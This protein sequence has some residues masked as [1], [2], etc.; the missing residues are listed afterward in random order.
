MKE[1]K[2]VEEIDPVSHLGSAYSV[3]RV[4]CI[5]MVA[6]VMARH[7]GA[8]RVPICEGEH[9]LKKFV[10]LLTLED[11]CMYRIVNNDSTGE[12]EKTIQR[13][14]N[15]YLPCSHMGPQKPRQD[16]HCVVNH[17]RQNG[18]PVGLVSEHKKLLPHTYVF[19]FSI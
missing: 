3:L 10:H 16:S 14:P 17:N 6:E 19:H 15:Q 4:L 9:K 18:T 11:G 12:G 13:H 1:E 5:F 2:L 7:I 8:H